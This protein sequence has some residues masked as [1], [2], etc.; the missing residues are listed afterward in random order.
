MSAAAYLKSSFY[1]QLVEHAFISEVLQEVWFGHGETVE[2]LRS[3]VDSAGYDVVFECKGVLRHVQLKTSKSDAKRQTQNVNIA[4]ADK[5]SGCIVWL[6]RHEDAASRRV[7]LSYLFFGSP[8]GQPLPSLSD[9]R[10]GKHSK[11]DATGKKNERPSIRLVPKSRF[12]RIET[13]TELVQQLFGLE[14]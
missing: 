2:V 14:Q 9:F 11:G 10:I 8:P 12:V 6:V 7:R 4:L 13:T 3:E 1:E 5:P